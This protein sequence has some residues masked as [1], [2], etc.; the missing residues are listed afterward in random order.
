MGYGAYF[1]HA[2]DSSEDSSNDVIPHVD[3][4]GCINVKDLSLKSFR[5]RL[6][7]HFNIAFKENLI[8]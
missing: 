5:N 8:V 7:Q 4:D 2:N 6:I 3:L 1:I